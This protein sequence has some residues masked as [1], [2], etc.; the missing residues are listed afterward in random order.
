[1][2]AALLGEQTRRSYLD[3]VR[4]IDNLTN[5]EV[6]WQPFTNTLHTACAPQGLSSLC[7]WDC[8][9]WMMKMSLVHEMYV[10]EYHVE[11]VMR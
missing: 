11:C 5:V 8:E 9:F 1:L 2:Y 3:F 10:E 6:I 7:F 4:Q